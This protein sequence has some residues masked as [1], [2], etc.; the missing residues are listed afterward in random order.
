MELAKY[1][2]ENVETS[3]DVLKHVIHS[4]SMEELANVHD[5]LCRADTQSLQMERL[6]FLIDSRLEPKEA[7]KKPKKPNLP[8]QVLLDDFSDN[9]SGK[10]GLSRLEL[11]KRFDYQSFEIQAKIVEAFMRKGTKKDVVWCSKYFVDDYWGKSFWKEEYLCVVKSYW[12]SDMENYKLLKVI[13]WYASKD[14]LN[15]K[16]K[17]IESETVGWIESVAYVRLLVGLGKAD[18]VDKNRLNPSNYAYVCAKTGRKITTGDAFFAI[19]WAVVNEIQKGWNSC[20]ALGFSRSLH[21]KLVFKVTGELGLSLWSVAELGHTDV[22]IRF[23]EWIKLVTNE[24]EALNEFDYES[25]N[26]TISMRIKDFKRAS[27][28]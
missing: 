8:I 26:K 17:F 24:L 14:Y 10:V 23:N 20:F 16:K 12:E 19:L 7:I 3:Y 13:E 4:L 2:I 9:K 1:L 21:G 5:E 22:V 25:I 18:K 27:D 15:E 28:V 11:Q 6:L